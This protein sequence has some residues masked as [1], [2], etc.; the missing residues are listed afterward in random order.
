MI[1]PM[2]KYY[3][4]LYHKTYRDF[5][6]KLRETGL[7]DITTTGWEPTEEDRDLLTAIERHRQAP[8]RLEPIVRE[9]GKQS[10]EPFSSPREAY[11]NY[12]EAIVNLDNL[13][14]K[15]HHTEKETAQLEV[16]GDFSMERVRALAADGIKIRF[17]SAYS[18][19]FMDNIEK[20]SESYTIE[21]ISEVEGITYFVVVTSPGEEV[22]INAQEQ[23]Q[24]TATHLDKIEEE[25]SLREQIARWQRVL[26]RVAA[27]EKL[28]KRHERD[29]I[30][31]LQYRR[32]VESS[33]GEAEGALVVLQG[34]ATQETSEQVDKLIDEH[35]DMIYI[36]S[37][38]TP[39]DD[40][41]VLLRNNKFARPFE[42]IGGFYSPPKYG[43]TDLTASFAPFY[44][45]FFGFCL[46]EA[47]Y[48]LLIVL[49]GLYMLIK[50]NANMKQLGKLTIL[51]G[52][53][54]MAFGFLSG[55]FFGIQLA[56][57]PAFERFHEIFL[58]PNHLFVLALVIGFVQLLFGMIVNIFTR[59]RLFGFKYALSSIGWVLVLCSTLTAAILPSAGIDSFTFAS[60]LYWVLAGVGA[61]MMLFLNSPGKNPMANLGTGLWNTYN[62]VSGF[63]GDILSYI[64]LFAIGLS[65][66]IL[67]LVFNDLAFGMTDGMP[68]VLR[69]ILI[70]VI[71]LIGHGINLFMSVLSSF[72]HPLRLTFVEFYKNAGFEPGQRIFTPFKKE[73]ENKL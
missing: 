39:E 30:E 42:F 4:V 64:R 3:F 47:G 72:V 71:L 1:V 22:L 45:I 2:T 26:L 52:L 57:V 56:G 67:A 40:T 51:C 25:K 33:H 43:T 6:E 41:P 70:I 49:A 63:V 29:S 27:S 7:V 10:A 38:P 36:K 20:W 13:T 37:R 68:I 19:D 61:F 46:A 8:G 9:Y 69:V 11:D 21:R 12:A 59:T 31:E 17:F 62:N 35:P 34:W 14:A 48:G 58:S 55:S 18:K 73:T 54:G 28:M 16:W 44:M 65:G 15:L 5:L 50:G 32:V 23:K 66:G 24:L 60:P 53:S